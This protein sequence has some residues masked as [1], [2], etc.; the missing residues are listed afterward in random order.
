MDSLY[1]IQKKILLA[2]EELSLFSDSGGAWD[3]TETVFFGNKQSKKT[4]NDTPD[5]ASITESE[6][7]L[8]ETDTFNQ[9][10]IRMIRLQNTVVVQSAYDK[11]L[12]MITE[13]IT[14]L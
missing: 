8:E 6:E 9:P 13:S 10:A 5:N 7:N 14:K 11:A 3:S 1:Y 4:S 12:R 2:Q